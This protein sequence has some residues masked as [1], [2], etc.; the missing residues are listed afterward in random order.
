MI[1]IPFEALCIGP[2]GDDA[3][4]LSRETVG[5]DPEVLSLALSSYST[6]RARHE[7]RSDTLTIIDYSL[8]SIKKRLW[9]IDLES[10]EIL[11]H[12]LVAHGKNTGENRATSFSNRVG[13]LQSSL[14]TFIT[15]DT[16]QGKHGYTL[17][18]KGMDPG[19]NHRAE[20]RL[21]VLHG[22]NYVSADYVAREGRLGRS[23]GCPAVRT[24]IA[25]PL[26]DAIKGGSVLF[27]YYPDRRLEKSSLY[28][29]SAR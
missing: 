6:A 16:Y 28:L 17:N 26:I 18:L 25:K 9:V 2:T 15:G 5:L 11:F 23:W 12:E 22:A 24:S 29:H 19:I 10:N 3:A 1:L 20:E 14:G 7:T 21:I 27:A 4:S 8:P 13:S